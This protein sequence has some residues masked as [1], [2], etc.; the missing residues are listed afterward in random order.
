MIRLSPFWLILYSYLM[1]DTNMK[2][3]ISCKFNMDTACVEFKFLNGDPE[4]YPRQIT[5]Y[6]PLDT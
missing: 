3:I 6:H 5:D 4:A 2:P 1:E